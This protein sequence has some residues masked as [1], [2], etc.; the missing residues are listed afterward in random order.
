MQITVAKLNKELVTE[1]ATTAANDNRVV[2]TL[3][4]Q[5]RKLRTSK[6]RSV[7]NGN[8]TKRGEKHMPTVLLPNYLNVPNR[9]FK[10]MLISASENVLSTVKHEAVR[11]WLNISTNMEYTREQAR[12][13]D[14]LLFLQ[15]QQ[16]L[17]ADYLHVGSTNNVWA[18]EVL[19]KIS[20]KAQ[21]DCSVMGGPLPFVIR[22]RKQIDDQLLSTENELNEHFN[23]FQQVRR[24]RSEVQLI[25][26]L[27]RILKAL[28]RKGQYRLTAEFQCKKQLLVFDC[29]DHRLTKAFFDL[30][31]T[32]QHVRLISNAV[33]LEILTHKVVFLSCMV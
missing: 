15:L 24:S 22:F 5:Q 4:A 12:L 20:R 7:G 6:S 17:W 18:S 9:I 11:R 21:K 31:P 8:P 30:K 29:Q 10:Q 28:I 27:S 14:R 25:A 26:D 16:S 33:H 23:R 13:L 32:K 2:Q 3:D 1:T 19:A